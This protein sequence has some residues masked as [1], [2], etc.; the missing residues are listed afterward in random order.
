MTGAASFPALLERF[1][2]DRLLHQRQ[3]SPHTVA[4]YRDTFRLLVQFARQRLA[5][6]PC[7]L[8]MA[9]LDTPFVGE[10]LDYLEHGRGNAARS[11]TLSRQGTQGALYAAAQGYRRRAADLVAGASRRA[12]RPPVSKRPRRP[13][14]S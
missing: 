7:D 3:A 6:A 10:F 9:D 8:A 14:Q 1:F 11:R 5:K 4:S 12:D 13:A 2:T